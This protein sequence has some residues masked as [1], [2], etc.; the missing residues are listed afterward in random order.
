MLGQMQNFD[1]LPA[2]DKML[3]D[4]QPYKFGARLLL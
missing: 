2:R 1:K 4:D 3:L